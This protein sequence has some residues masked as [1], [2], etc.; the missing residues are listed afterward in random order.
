MS[1]VDWILDALVRSSLQGAV[2]IGLVWIV[3]RLF[4]RLPASIRCGLWWAA[5]L[6]LLI[7]LVW[8]S[9]VE[10]PLL[11]AAE[12]Q[13]VPIETI[14]APNAPVVNVARVATSPAPMS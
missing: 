12:M 13:P 1:A 10:L 5:C 4:P 11:P 2:F 3:C 7:G 9:P 8:V 6:K 14:G